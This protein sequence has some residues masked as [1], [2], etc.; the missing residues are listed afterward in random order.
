MNYRKI[1]D[2]FIKSRINVVELESEHYEKH[3]IIPKCDGGGDNC[4]NI[5]RLTPAEHYF[6]HK[7]LVKVYQQTSKFDIYQKM[8]YAANMMS[9]ASPN[10]IFRTNHRYVGWVRTLFIKNHPNKNQQVRD[11][12]SKS[13]KLY[14]IGL[15][16]S[17]LE[18]LNSK[19]VFPYC[20]LKDEFSDG[21]WKLGKNESR[22]ETKTKQSDALKEYIQSLDEYERSSRLE[23]S[24]HKHLN[25]PVLAKSRGDAISKG[26]KGKTTNQ[27]EIMG[28][29]YASMT[30]VEFKDF[31]STL[32]PK[33]ENRLTN[34]RNRYLN[35]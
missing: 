11:K 18:I 13:L 29:R 30:D 14:N 22:M 19:G 5:V 17:K 7:L 4:D 33:S 6:A 21:T 10:G 31:L 25:D 8:I 9:N 32:S 3:H 23:N 24:L 15:Y 26:K 28:K 1:Y 27:I 20:K 12:L 2:D 34:I 16:D 35:E